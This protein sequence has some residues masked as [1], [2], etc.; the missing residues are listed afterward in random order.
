MKTLAHKS[1]IDQDKL[2]AMGDNN[3]DEV[4]QQLQD[5]RELNDDDDMETVQNDDSDEEEMQRI[6]RES[7]VYEDS[8]DEKD[9]DEDEDKENDDDEEAE[10]EDEEEDEDEDAMDVDDSDDDQK[11]HGKSGKQSLKARIKEEQ[12]IRLKEKNIRN[13]TDQPKSIDD[14]ERLVVANTDQSYVWI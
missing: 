1:G 2:R 14:F 10:D 4:E 5:I 9:K 3:Q 6:I 12:A 8:N 13:N 11:A 7:K